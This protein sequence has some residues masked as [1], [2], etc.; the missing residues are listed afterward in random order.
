[1]MA[2]WHDNSAVSGKAFNGLRLI[3]QELWCLDT[4]FV[5]W[6]CR[7]SLRMTVIETSVGLL[8]YSPVRLTPEVVAEI[9][10]IGR[11]A[12]IVA[13]NLFH[14]MFLR[15]S[16]V[17]F[18]EARVLVAD[19]LESKI[20]T[21][22]GS[23]AITDETAFG[24]RD[25][26]DHFVFDGHALHETILLHRPSATLITADLLYNYGPLQYPAERAFFRA[27][28]CY[29]IPKVPFYHKFSIRNKQSVRRLIDTVVSWRVRRII[30]SHGDIIEN[31]DASLLFA[32]AWAPFAN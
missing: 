26:I 30:M 24:A 25:E 22:A 20:G 29:G 6:G 31:K 15:P 17:T 7:G 16:R 23:E 12:V 2:C 9:K 13:P 11:V 21:I 3:D 32:A 4:H 28:G 1:M 18:P 19:G 14:H 10:R 8:L 5:V 27:I